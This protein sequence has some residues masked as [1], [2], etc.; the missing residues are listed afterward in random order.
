[1]N[2]T[3]TKLKPCPFCGGEAKIFA[4]EVSY[5]KWNYE[6]V[7][8]YWVGC[9]NNDCSVNPK[10]TAYKTSIW[11]KQDGHVVMEQDGYALA[12]EAWNGRAYEIRENQ[13]NI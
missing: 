4:G 2:M 8:P 7:R 3:E 11:L 13:T 6:V 1:M 10:T 9:D 5:D 12:V